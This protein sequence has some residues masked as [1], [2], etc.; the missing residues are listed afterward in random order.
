MEIIIAVNGY[1]PVLINSQLYSTLHETTKLLF[2]Y[3]ITKRVKYIVD[4]EQLISYSLVATPDFKDLML[5]SPSMN[6]TNTNLTA[7]G[8]NPCL[9]HS[10]TTSIK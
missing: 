7:M 3:F 9:Y 6:L 1:A 5:N 4:C 8:L 10:K 2:H